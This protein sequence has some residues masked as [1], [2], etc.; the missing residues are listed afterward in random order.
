MMFTRRQMMFG[1][2]AF[3]G[4]LLKPSNSLA[5]T[6]SA[7]H[8]D[9]ALIEARTGGRLGVMLTEHGSGRSFAYRGDER[10]PMCSTVKVLVCGAVLER[11]DTGRESLDR[12][13]RF[14]LSDLQT[15]SP[16]TKDHVGEDGMTISSLCEAAIT[17]SDNTAMNLLTA[18]VGGPAGVTQFARSL[19]DTTTR[20]DRTETTLNEAV[21]GDPRDTTTPTAMA[22]TL[23]ALV[24]GLVLSPGSRDSLRTWMVANSTGDAKLRAGV[25]KAWQVG[26]KTG[27]GAHGTSNDIGILWRGSLPPICAIVYLTGAETI[28]ES[29]RAAASAAVGQI[30]GR[31]FSA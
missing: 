28:L 24:L 12:R 8:A 19:G 1:G 17:L 4:H 26:D 25:P 22:S 29:A 21:P 14:T 15:Y 2:V 6:E 10:F 31:A 3:A 18:S 5:Q 9:F 30:A 23:S 27:T 20:L 16:A 13:I 11:V 7:I